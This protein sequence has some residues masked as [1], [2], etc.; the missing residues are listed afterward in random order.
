MSLI[1][2]KNGKQVSRT[3]YF[4]LLLFKS[5]KKLHFQIH[6][7]IHTHLTFHFSFTELQQ[8]AAQLLFFEHVRKSKMY[9]SWN[10]FLFFVGCPIMR[11]NGLFSPISRT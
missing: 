8:M 11:L 5:S 7:Y 2:P 6:T 4:R 3:S 1:S 10:F 9:S